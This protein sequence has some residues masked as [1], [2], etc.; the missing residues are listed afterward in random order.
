MFNDDTGAQVFAFFLLLLFLFGGFAVYMNSYNYDKKSELIR[1]IDACSHILGGYDSVL[2]ITTREQCAEKCI[3]LENKTVQITY[4]AA[5]VCEAQQCPAT[6]YWD[7][8]S[9]DW[10]NF[11]YEFNNTPG[12]IYVKNG[13]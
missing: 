8:Y 11:T 4:K 5:C 1:C 9:P 10:V 12:W 6:Y 3:S 7:Y 2:I 13:K